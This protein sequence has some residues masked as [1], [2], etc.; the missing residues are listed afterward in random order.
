[1][2]WSRLARV[3]GTLSS[4]VMIAAACGDDD[5]SAGPEVGVDVDDLADGPDLGD[6]LAP[7][8][9][10]EVQVSG[11]VSE[12]YESDAFEIAGPDGSALVIP[13]S[14]VPEG[15]E[16]GAL[17]QAD[18][19]VRLVVVDA[20][21]DD[22]G[23]VYNDLYTDFVERYALAADNLVVLEGDDGDG[24]GGTPAGNAPLESLN[25]SEVSGDTA[26]VLR[27]GQLEVT[28]SAGGL[29]PDL[30]HAMHVHFAAGE[31]SECP[32]PGE[33]DVDGDGLLT[34]ADG[35]PSYGSVQIALT[36]DGDFG[37]DSALAL[38]RFPV[39]DGDGNLEFQR[40][41]DLDDEMAEMLGGMQ[42]AVVVHGTDLDLSGDYDGDAESSLDPSVPLEATL[43]VACGTTT[44]D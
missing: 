17:V 14:A 33:F 43:P 41:F 19:T 21:E 34:T 10:S 15:L 37:A 30:A 7:L 29:S 5:D 25:E 16:E 28:L 31:A 38:D 22:F 13:S 12:V 35:V 36:T 24:T 20:F 4:L 23:V 2:S 1:M 42:V 9:G 32:P 27:D 40:T 26:L 8:E 44:L 18:G 11:E 6:P 3:L 39:A